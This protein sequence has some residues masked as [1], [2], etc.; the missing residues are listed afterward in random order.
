M[1]G[2]QLMGHS[3][4]LSC[5]GWKKKTLGPS[6]LEIAQKYKSDKS[7]ISK[8]SEKVIKGGSGSWGQIPMIAH[9]DLSENDA[10]EMVKAIL[11]MK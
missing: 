7:A 4:C 6:F 11:K 8:L 5:H 1:L 2:A 3:D 9:P 10:K